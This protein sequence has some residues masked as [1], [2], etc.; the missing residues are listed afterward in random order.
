MER[1][2]LTASATGK[3]KLHA[4]TPGKS[5]NWARQKHPCRLKDER[6]ERSDLSDAEILESF[7]QSDWAS[8][9]LA[10]VSNQ[11]SQQV[12]RLA[13]SNAWNLEL[14]HNIFFSSFK[15]TFDTFT[16]CANCKMELTRQFKGV[17]IYRF[18]LAP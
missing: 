1:K 3:S 9:Y 13:G 17:E 12:N 11:A 5:D 14:T 8:I 18:A 16:K 7:L 6:N 4:Q 15:E 2:P 10:E